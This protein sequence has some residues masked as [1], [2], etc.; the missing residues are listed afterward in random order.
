MPA[1][2]AATAAHCTGRT[3]G[4]GFGQR[5]PEQRS[6]EARGHG[7]QHH[8]AQHQQGLF[9]RIAQAHAAAVPEKHR[10]RQEDHRQ[11]PHH[12]QEGRGVAL[13]HVL[14]SGVEGGE[15]HQRG[16]EQQDAG[17][18]GGGRGGQ[19]GGGDG[20]HVRGRRV[21]CLEGRRPTPGRSPAPCSR[22]PARR[23]WARPGWR[24]A[25]RWRGRRRCRA[26]AR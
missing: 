11:I 6:H 10:H 8:A 23:R 26:S 25:R 14:G 3:H 1:N 9:R 2:P 13:Q 5:H 18:A 21:P 12:I 16:E 19:D 15:R 22:L 24:R 4:R 7:R 20:G 17:V